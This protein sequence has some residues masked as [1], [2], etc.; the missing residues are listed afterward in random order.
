MTPNHVLQYDDCCACGACVSKCKS[1]AIELMPDSHGNL[2]PRIDEA[3]CVN[4]GLCKTVCPCNNKS[5]VVESFLKYFIGFYEDEKAAI[6]SSSGGIFA[7]LAK[8]V[9]EEGGVVFG[10]AIDYENGKLY[11]K[12]IKIDTIDDLKKIQGSKYVHSK[13]QGIFDEIR[14]LLNSGRRVLFSGTSCQVMA[15]KTFLGKEDPRLYTIDLVCHGVP[16]I[17]LFQEYISYLEH[18]W[19]CR[20]TDVSFRNKLAPSYEKNKDSYVLTLTCENPKTGTKD[21]RYI[22]KYKSAYYQLFLTR[23][24]YRENCYICPYAALEKPSDITLGDFRPSVSEI[25][26]M[27]L[28]KDRVYSSVIIHSKKGES[29]LA[30]LP[31]GRITLFEVSQDKMLEHHYNLV[32]PSAIT[33]GGK[34]L[35]KIYKST[36]FRGLQLFINFKGTFKK[37]LRKK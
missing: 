34:K 11:C 10:A 17:T 37:I 29:L 26:E 16:E 4:C 8:Y 2:A 22:P 14:E 5:N 1:A 21:I 15:L 35:A 20:I 19:K 24:Y 31:T 12:H 33:P 30:S 28:N 27:S 9:L 6:L 13:T 36:G 23:A 7:G 32:K 25:Q 3:A 18:K